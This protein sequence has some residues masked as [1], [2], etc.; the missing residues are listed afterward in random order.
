MTDLLALHVR[1]AMA[2]RSIALSI[3]VVVIAA[4][5]SGVLFLQI[6]QVNCH[7][8]CADDVRTLDDWKPA[9]IVV[10]GITA[11]ILMVFAA[12][13]SIGFRCRHRRGDK[14]TTAKPTVLWSVTSGQE[15]RAL[16]LP[17]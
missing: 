6:G 7:C 8:T 13:L 4:L 2:R 16:I 15:E 5:V 14:L 12:G 11:G 10:M 1:E 3:S 9:R 17:S